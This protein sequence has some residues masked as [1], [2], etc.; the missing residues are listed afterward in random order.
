V[1]YNPK[2][3]A[4]WGSS[5]FGGNFPAGY[6]LDG[7]QVF[8]ERGKLING[9]TN[10]GAYK[11]ENFSAFVTSTGKDKTSSF[12]ILPVNASQDIPTTITS[13]LNTL[14]LA[15][16]KDNI[17]QINVNSIKGSL[18]EVKNTLLTSSTSTLADQ[19]IKTD[20]GIEIRHAGSYTKATGGYVSFYTDVIGNGYAKLFTTTITD[21][22]SRMDLTMDYML[23]GDSVN[24]R[25]TVGKV[26][27]QV[28]PSAVLGLG[29]KVTVD[30]IEFLDFNLGYSR[31]DFVAVVEQ[32]TSSAVVVSL[33]FNVAKKNWSRLC[34]QP[35]LLFTTNPANEP[36]VFYNNHPLVTNL[37]AGTKILP[38]LDPMYVRKPAVGTTVPTIKPSYIG[39]Q[40][41]NTSTKKVYIATGVATLSDWTVMN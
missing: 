10:G 18:E 4:Y 22:N 12:F 9:N 8:I 1:F 39:Q 24:N 16:A 15:S 31:T 3:S 27:L 40:Y 2:Q 28:I 41:I 38:S 17:L 35:N 7:N 13:I 37:P 21:G 19:V 23:C 14:G 6:N 30:V 5:S 36:Y 26:N 20:R 33:Y 34:Y 11:V 25:K 32:E 29:T